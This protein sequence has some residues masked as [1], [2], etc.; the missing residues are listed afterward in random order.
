MTYMF[1]SIEQVYLQKLVKTFYSL[2]SKFSVCSLET[3]IEV[4]FNRIEIFLLYFGTVLTSIH[5]KAFRQ[6][7]AA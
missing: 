1:K 6:K 2:H 7:I 5:E 4:H 3:S